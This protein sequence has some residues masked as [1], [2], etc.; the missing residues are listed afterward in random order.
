M[1][2]VSI[3][4]LVDPKHYSYADFISVHTMGAPRMLIASEYAEKAWLRFQD[5]ERLKNHANVCI[6]QGRATRLEPD[7]KKLYYEN[8]SPG[9]KIV[10]EMIRY[11]YLVVASGLRRQWPTVPKSV[12]K[13]QY[14]ADAKEYMEGLETAREAIVVIGGGDK[15]T[16]ANSY[17]GADTL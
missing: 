12:T 10:E 15:S 6:L 1:E 11:D 13:S 9:Y 2:S 8:T 7:V 3:V 4:T 14:V 5:I 17:G 16:W